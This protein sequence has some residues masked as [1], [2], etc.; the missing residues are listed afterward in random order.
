[1]PDAA[2][3]DKGPERI[4]F[5]G[6][7]PD[8]FRPLGPECTLVTIGQPLTHEELE[9]LATLVQGRPD[10]TLRFHTRAARD[11]EFLAY[12]PHLQRLSVAL[13]ELEDISGFSH[14][15]GSLEHL[16]FGKTKKRFSLGF[17]EMMPALR[18]LSLESHT[19]DIAT[20]SRLVQLT[21]LVFRG[22]TL[23]DL[24]LIASLPELNTFSLLLGGTKHLDHLAEAPRLEVLSLMRISKLADLSVLARL[25]FLKTLE[26]DGMRNVTAL[27][28][29]APLTRLEDV[30]LETMKGLTD[31]SPV[32]AAPALRQL[33]IAGMPQLDA[34]AF[35]CLV[36]HPSLAQL[37]LWS[38]LGGVN[39]K[40]PVL[41]AVKQL[42][43]MIVSP[44]QTA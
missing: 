1:M 15:Q 34:N 29:L 35:R 21:T 13:W 40:K 17:L 25:R 33:V 37:R 26:L 39:L 28:S 2:T 14:L 24:S 30:T 42:L 22:V 18:V 41:E 20:L 27:P 4:R 36:G 11:L 7:T 12:F 19:K 8:S 6:R 23:P 5:L 16:D 31:I 43:P 32:A 44:L 10:V 9:Q 3:R 38:S